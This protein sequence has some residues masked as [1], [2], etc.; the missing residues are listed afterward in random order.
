MAFPVE[1]NVGFADL[2]PARLKDSIRQFYSSG[3]VIV[4]VEAGITVI[5]HQSDVNG[6][7]RVV[8][9]SKK[10]A[11]NKGM[12]VNLV[13]GSVGVRLGLGG[14]VGKRVGNNALIATVDGVIFG[15]IDGRAEAVTCFALRPVWRS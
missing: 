15:R 8:A 9:N 14:P 4:E 11:H 13:E 1:D 2:V 3:T 5:L 12:A 10:F 6:A 7:G